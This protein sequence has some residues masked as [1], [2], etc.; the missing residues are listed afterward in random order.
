MAENSKIEW[1]DHTVNLWWGCAKVHT[2]CKNC[3]AEE[4]SDKRYKK[5][6]WG[7][8][9]KRQR[10]KSA[11]SDLDKYQKKAL[12]MNVNYKI[13]C[14]SMMDI[15]EDNKELSN[16]YQSYINDILTT[17]DLRNKLFSKIDAGEYNNLIFLFLTKRPENIV[18]KIPEN[19]VK[20][21]PK[22][23]WFGTSVSN[24]E[25]ADKL[26]PKLLQYK[27]N[28][29]FLSIEPQ[30]DR[31]SFRWAFWHDYKSPTTAKKEII[32]GKR[33]LTW[34]QYDGIKGISWIIQGG[35]SGNNKRPF[36]VDWAYQM[37]LDCAGAGVSYFFKQIDKKQTV[38]DDLNIKQLP[39]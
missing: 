25:T 14:G 9:E 11:F 7:E 2:G 6:L 18:L 5:N 37:K 31:V 4:L 10:V 32:N 38:P 17:D 34:G 26:I 8:N 1:C 36:N 22:N 29:L 15:F 39:F 16:P 19:W 20:C 28:N 35:E 24:Q 30:V 23:V 12:S 13:F 3:Y 27:P 33:C 21:A